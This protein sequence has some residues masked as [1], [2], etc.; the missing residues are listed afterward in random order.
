MTDTRKIRE[1]LG[2]TQEALAARLGTTVT[3]ISR[4]ECGRKRPVGKLMLAA[5][6]RLATE[7]ERKKTS[8]S[9]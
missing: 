7:A 5:I 1:A 2:M 8:D 9:A 6:A 4:W 3:T